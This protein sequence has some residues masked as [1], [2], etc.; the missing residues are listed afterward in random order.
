MA[1]VLEEVGH[2]L[3]HHA[4]GGQAER[5]G[6]ERRLAAHFERDAGAGAGDHR[7]DLG[8]GGGGAEGGRLLVAAHER[9]DAAHLADGLAAGV[10]DDAQCLDGG[11]GPLG[12]QRLRPLRL[13]DDDRQRVGQHVVQFLRDL[14]ARSAGGQL[15]FLFGLP[16]GGD[17]AFGDDLTI[18]GLGEDPLT[19]QPAQQVGEGDDREAQQHQ[20]RGA[21]EG[22]GGWQALRPGV[23]PGDGADERE[24]QHEEPRV[25]ALVARDAVG[26]ERHR[27]QR[28]E[29][30]VERQD[31]AHAGEGDHAERKQRKEAP[32]EDRRAHQQ[33][34]SD[35]GPDEPR[36]ADRQQRQRRAQRKRQG[37][38]TVDEEGASVARLPELAHDGLSLRPAAASPAGQVDWRP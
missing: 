17:E 5:L 35:G 3:L 9:H 2:G 19:V 13:N 20:Q 25:Q 28:R 27:E 16:L 15:E 36:A 6:H 10:G 14:G 31:H 11:L 34:P 29:R 21:E 32:Y 1:G 37:Q 33:R 26:H 4:V 18:E 8:E 30:R 38:R 24:Q 7:G 12:G 23:G 22:V